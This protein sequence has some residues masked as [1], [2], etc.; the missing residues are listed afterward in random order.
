MFL[1][2]PTWPL[3]NPLCFIARKQKQ[4]LLLKKRLVLVPRSAPWLL[5]VPSRSPRVTY[6]QERCMFLPMQDVSGCEDAAGGALGGH[7]WG[8]FPFV[9]SWDSLVLATR[10]LP[11]PCAG[12]AAATLR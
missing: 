6:L 11:L 5:P 7:P 8:M 9:P 3:A 2:S 12:G 10:H 4:R 1:L